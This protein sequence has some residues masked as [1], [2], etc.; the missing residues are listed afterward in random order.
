[1]TPAEQNLHCSV[2][3]IEGNGVVLFGPSGSG[4]STLALSLIDQ[5]RAGGGSACLVSDDQAFFATK[6]RQLF[7]EAPASIAGKIEVFGVGIVACKNCSRTR[8][9]L[10]VRLVDKNLIERHPEPTTTEILGIH[11]QELKVPI[12]NEAIAARMIRARLGLL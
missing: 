3:A 7:A 6:N 1:M 2:V 5:V 9:D 4:K 10:V 8:V 12:Q 11:L